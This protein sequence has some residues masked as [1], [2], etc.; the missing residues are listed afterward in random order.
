MVSTFR[1]L[2]L[3]ASLVGAALACGLA[4]AP[5]KALTLIDNT[6]QGTAVAG[7]SVGAITGGDKAAITFSTSNNF[8]PYNRFLL[9]VNLSQI[10]PG[11]SSLDDLSLEIYNVNGSN[12]P[13]G[14]AI[15]SKL[16]TS[17]FGSGTAYGNT[18]LYFDTR[19]PTTIGQ[20]PFD[21]IANSTYAIALSGNATGG[22]ISGNWTWNQSN[23]SFTSGT[24]ATFLA[25][26]A[27]SPS[28]WSSISGNPAPYF[29]LQ[30]VPGPLPVLGAGSAFAWS[31]RLRRRV[32]Q[33]RRAGQ[34]AQVES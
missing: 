17:P 22:G 16:F 4:P 13:T 3:S 7:S 32:S 34:A 15:Y 30:G 33:A 10:T 23:S 11:S 2:A 9:T 25:S 21:L 1:R 20:T 8:S 18:T 12:I 5:A 6:N 14:S 26:S 28:T 27:F 29:Y 24:S 31:R 19:N